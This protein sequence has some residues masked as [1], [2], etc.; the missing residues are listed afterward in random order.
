MEDPFS[1]AAAGSNEDEPAGGGGVDQIHVAQD[2]A[3]LMYG[4]SKE[5]VG[6]DQNACRGGPPRSCY[7][8]PSECQIASLEIDTRI[9]VVHIKEHA[10]RP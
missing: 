6:A 8:L 4:I 3:E 1:S 10:L 7:P 5:F 9:A 2:I